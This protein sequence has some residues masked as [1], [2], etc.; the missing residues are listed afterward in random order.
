MT[1]G[2]IESAGWV[3]VKLPGKIRFVKPISR[4]AKKKLAQKIYTLGDF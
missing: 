1:K 2:Q 4:F 3:E